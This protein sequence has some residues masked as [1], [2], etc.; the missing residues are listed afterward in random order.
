MLQSAYAVTD[1]V[2]PFAK[3][4]SVTMPIAVQVVV[5]LG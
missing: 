2:F 1:N 3:L 5:L 4:E